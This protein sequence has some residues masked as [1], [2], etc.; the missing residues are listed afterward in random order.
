MTRLISKYLLSLLFIVS[1]PAANSQ[2]LSN[3]NP[4]SQS[5]IVNGLIF[6]SGQTDVSPVN[7]RLVDSNF[8]MEVA[9]VMRQI[10]HILKIYRLDFSAVV[11]VTVYLQD[12]HQY[13]AFNRVYIKYFKTPL[14]SRSCVAV[15]SI[16]NGA[17]IEIAAIAAIKK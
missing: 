11:S 3:L 9:G 1:A 13:D 14:P 5:R 7:G 12:I 2:A 8:D 4:Y 10:K 6:I 15:K 16:P 17:H